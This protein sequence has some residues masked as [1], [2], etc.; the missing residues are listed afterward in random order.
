MLMTVFDLVTYPNS[1]V[2]W[3]LLGSAWA[4]KQWE[5]PVRRRMAVIGAAGVVLLLAFTFVPVS[6]AVR[7]VNGYQVRYTNAAGGDPY[8]EWLTVTRPDGSTVETAFDAETRRCWFPTP[9][10][11]G[12]QLTFRCFGGYTSESFLDTDQWIVFVDGC[13]SCQVK[14]FGPHN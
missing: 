5:V 12:S 4:L 7:L 3:S 9:V 1:M 13:Q 10:Q 6:T 8:Y 2:L 14:V 11:T